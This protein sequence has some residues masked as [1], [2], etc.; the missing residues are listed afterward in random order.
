[1]E[2]VNTVEPSPPIAQ[3]YSQRHQHEEVYIVANREGLLKMKEAI[4]KALE[5]EIGFATEF[6]VD[7]E[8]YDIIILNKNE[9]W[10]DESWQTLSLPYSEEYYHYGESIHPYGLLTG[11]QKEAYIKHARGESKK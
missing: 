2:H 8:G 10:Q 11:E 3:I 6:I 1:M 4:D 5:N 9:H 7:G